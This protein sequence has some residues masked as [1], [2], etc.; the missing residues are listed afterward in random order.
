M[1]FRPSPVQSLIGHPCAEVLTK[2]QDLRKM[3]RERDS[4]IMSNIPE[5]PPAFR[6]VTIKLVTVFVTL[7][8]V[9]WGGPA[10]ES[11]RGFEII[12]EENA[13]HPHIEHTGILRSIESE[14]VLNIYIQIFISTKNMVRLRTNNAFSHANRDAYLHIFLETSGNSSKRL[15]SNKA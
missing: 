8:L 1:A 4:K 5:W 2:Q 11:K 13:R 6:Y 12:S 9:R 7:I 3:L 14:C 15:A 10:V